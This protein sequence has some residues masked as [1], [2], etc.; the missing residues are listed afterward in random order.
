MPKMWTQ[1]LQILGRFRSCV[2]TF[3]SIFCQPKHC[4][5]TS[6][7]LSPGAALRVIASI[8]PSFWP[9][10]QPNPRLPCRPACKPRCYWLAGRCAFLC[11]SL[12][13]TPRLQPGF[14]PAFFQCA[15]GCGLPQFLKTRAFGVVGGGAGGG[16][17]QA[18]ADGAQA[19]DQGSI[20]SALAA[21][22]CRSM[23]GGP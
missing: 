20:S 18:V 11:F 8:F 10:L 7:N 13:L 2:N 12:L 14:A 17:A 6:Y 15:A 21:S 23:L 5:K 1:S 19:F 16:V 22:N 9:S 4:W 3:P